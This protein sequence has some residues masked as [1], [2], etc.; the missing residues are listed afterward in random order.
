MDIYRVIKEPHITEKAS[1]QKELNNQ[2]SFKV[3]RRAT[4][5][6][7]RQAVESLLNAK[8]LGVK[9]INMRGKKRRLGRN[10][11]KRPDWKKAIVKLAPGENIEFFESV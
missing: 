10:V 1:L 6:E 8:V 2:I 9:T 4:K 3:D 7:I 5:V 11:G